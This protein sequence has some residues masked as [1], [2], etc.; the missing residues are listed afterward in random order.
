MKRDENLVPLSREHHT[1]LLFCWKIRQ[2]L[3]KEA[4]PA[5][6][7]DYAQYFWAAHLRPHF[8]KEEEILL[9]MLAEDD[10]HR[11]RLEHE[12]RDIEEKVGK[13]QQ[14][15]SHEALESL[16]KMLY[17]HIRYEE[18]ELFPYLEQKVTEKQLRQIGNLLDEHTEP[19]QDE[20]AP[21]F[22]A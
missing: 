4:S 16:Q 12:H 19:L 1:G 8:R 11:Q 6:I 5:L 10:A 15:V 20:F 18:R 7:G 17:D 22:W 9:P 13:L 14:E 21:A 3:A 2:G